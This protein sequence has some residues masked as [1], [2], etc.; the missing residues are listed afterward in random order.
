VSSIAEADLEHLVSRAHEACKHAYC[1]YSKFP[2]GAALLTERGAVFSGCNV[3]NA[4]T[5]LTMCAERNAVFQMVAQGER[6]IKGVVMY[7]PT[8][9]P[10]TPCGACR[11]VINEFG[12]DAWIV[13]VCDGTGTIRAKMVEMLPWAFGDLP[14]G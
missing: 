2:V 8:P 6:H 13:C 10:Y 12:P 9:Q 4:S 14:A 11:Q 3:E 7:T 5:G 1:R